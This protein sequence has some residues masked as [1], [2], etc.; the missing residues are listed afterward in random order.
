[1]QSLTT[2]VQAQQ[3]ALSGLE[4][5]QQLIANQQQTI[6]THQQEIAA[7]KTALSEMKHL[8]DA[9]DRDLSAL[10]SQVR[11]LVNHPPQG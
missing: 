1:M 8:Q 7:L 6:A 2:Q 4:A 11:H 10:Q 9:R 5:S 3:T